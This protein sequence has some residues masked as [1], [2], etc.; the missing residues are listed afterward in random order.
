MRHAAVPRLAAC[1]HAQPQ[2][3]L[4]RHGDRKHRLRA[5]EILQPETPFVPDKF[6][7]YFRPM[8]LD[9]P[10]RTEFPPFLLV[11]GGEEDDVA[12]AVGDLS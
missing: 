8:L 3:F 2:I 6:R 4:L 12:A 5:E 9:H 10:L 1:F 7:L 11:G